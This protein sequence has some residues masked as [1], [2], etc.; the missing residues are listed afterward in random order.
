MKPHSFFGYVTLLALIRPKAHLRV[1][2]VKIEGRTLKASSRIEGKSLFLEGSLGRLNLNV[3]GIIAPDVRE[4]GKRVL[5]EIIDKILGGTGDEVVQAAPEK[6]R[7]DKSGGYHI[8]YHHYIDG[9]MVEGA[10]MML[11][12]DGSD[13]T[14]TAVNGEFGPTKLQDHDGERGLQELPCEQAIQAAVQQ[15]G[16]AGA[17]QESACELSA[18]YADDGYFQKA[19]K[20]LVGYE[21]G[22]EPYQLDEVFASLDVGRLLARFPTIHGG[23]GIETYDCNWSNTD[24]GLVSSNPEDILPFDP[25]SVLSQAVA[26]AHNYAIDT[27][28]Y[29]YYSYGRDSIDNRGMKLKSR[30]NYAREPGKPY[31]NAFWNGVYMTY[32]TG[33]RTTYY[34]FSRGCDVVA[35]EMMHGITQRTSGLRY[36]NESGALNEA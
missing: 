27:Y 10:S 15:L 11:H 36:V 1:G 28:N 8:R 12:V 32:G 17:T 23:L 4:E 14:V 25:S 33:D 5:E 21:A 2:A 34:P 3:Q 7:R 20:A 31:L 6:V 29:F 26:D 16:V 30:V 13:G 22:D 19:W 35:H 18:V 24:C 9:L